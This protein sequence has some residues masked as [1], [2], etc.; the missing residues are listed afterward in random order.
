M[1]QHH[2]GAVTM[3][4]E[5]F[6]KGGGQ[7][8]MAFKMASDIQVDQITEIAR[9]EKMT[10]LH[11]LQSDQT[12]ER[13]EINNAWF[14]RRPFCLAALGGRAAGHD[15]M[16]DID[17]TQRHAATHAASAC[18]HIRAGPA[19]WTERRFDERGRGGLEPGCAVEDAART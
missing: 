9:M 18:G 11:R 13:Y 2:K 3:V 8:D 17:T 5:L 1:I 12:K 15:R 16:R 7:D 14:C 6:E 4:H 19:C 10:Q